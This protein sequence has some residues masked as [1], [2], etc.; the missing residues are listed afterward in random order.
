VKV[1]E[2]PNQLQDKGD[3]FGEVP[4]PSTARRSQSRPRAVAFD[5]ALE[6][7]KFLLT[8]LKI[9]VILFVSFVVINYVAQLLKLSVMVEFKEFAQYVIPLFAFLFGMGRGR[10]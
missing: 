2:Q 4:Q 9:F 1:P 6:H 3:S 10:N 7:W 8:V 5:L